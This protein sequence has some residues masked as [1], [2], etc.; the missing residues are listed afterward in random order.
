MVAV[1]EKPNSLKCIFV[2]PSPNWNIYNMTSEPK[3]KKSIVEGR[4][5]IDIQRQK[6]R[7]ITVRL[8]LYKCQNTLIKSYQYG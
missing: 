8:C 6:T 4:E 5:E 2:E 3:T 1:L 7:K